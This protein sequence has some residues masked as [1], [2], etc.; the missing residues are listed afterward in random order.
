MRRM[1][2]YLSLDFRHCVLDPVDHF[3]LEAEPL[4]D[5]ER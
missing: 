3:E 4:L 2:T 5:E 1:K